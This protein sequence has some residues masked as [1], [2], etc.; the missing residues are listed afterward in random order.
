MSQTSYSRNHPVAQLGMRADARYDFVAGSLIAKEAMGIG[1][2]AVRS[3]DTDYN[4]R[5]PAINQGSL[6]FDAD[7]V[8]DNVVDLDVNGDSITS[9]PFNSTH[10][11]TMADLITQIELH[12][13]VGSA[14]LD[15]ADGTD[16]TL[17]VTAVDGEDIVLTNIVVT[18][19][20]SQAG[21]VW[22]SGSRDEIYGL[23]QKVPALIAV[24]GVV[25]YAINDAVN[26][27]RQGALWCYVE[28]AVTNYDPVF[29]RILT[30]A[31]LVPGNFRNDAASGEAIAV[32]NAKFI[33][34]ITAAGIC[35]IEINLP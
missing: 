9:V 28:E 16:R 7:I 30:N 1:L 17:I 27:V 23:I 11:L 6:V 14:I 29:C 18:L 10:A 12:A 34:T 21:G 33:N 24:A 22:T 20:G 26:L 25:A 8:T 2:G 19:G 15:P 32:P 3:F 31:T 13:D 4:C 35:P 5:L